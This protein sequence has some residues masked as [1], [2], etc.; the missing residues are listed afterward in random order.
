ML[1]DGK[2]YTNYFLK[3]IRFESLNGCS[4]FDESIVYSGK[5]AL[6]NNLAENTIADTKYDY[7]TLLASSVDCETLTKGGRLLKL[8]NKV[9]PSLYKRKL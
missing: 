6:E 3:R 4:K 8:N 5:G 7:N 1:F 2:E 9:D